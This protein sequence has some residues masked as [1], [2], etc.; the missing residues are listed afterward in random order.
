[1][2]EFKDKDIIQESTEPFR[3]SY[4]PND[5]NVN[6]NGSIHGGVMFYLCDDAIGRYVTSLGRVGAAADASIH[7]YRPGKPG[8]KMIATV[9]ERKIGR[10]LGV[11]LVELRNEAGVLLADSV[12]TVAFND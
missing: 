9:L 6:I 10:R 8:E 12:F 3:V 4:Q 1:M 11:L 7:Y 5:S 2:V